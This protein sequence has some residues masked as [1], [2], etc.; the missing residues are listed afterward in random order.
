MSD[1]RV[2]QA[3]HSITRTLSST[4]DQ[5]EGLR[6]TLEIAAQ[7]VDATGGSIWQHNPD[8]RQLVCRHVVGEK[9]A[10]LVGFT[11]GDAEG[12]AGHVFQ[13]RTAQSDT[14]L[15]TNPRH[16]HRVDEILQH[17]TQSLVTVP[18]SY[19]GG[20]AVGVIQLVNKRGG[21]FT[22]EDLTV[23]DIVA[24]VCAMSLLNA[25]LAQQAV[26]TEALGYVAGFA[27]DIYNKMTSFVTGLPTLRMLLDDVFTAV[28][29]ATPEELAR[30]REDAFSFVDFME[31]DA[32][33]VYRYAR[34]IARL[35]KDKPLDTR[36]EQSDLVETARAQVDQLRRNAGDLDVTL[37]L[38]GD[39]PIPCLHDRLLVGSA[40]Y[41]LVNNALPETRGGAVSVAVREENGFA[42]LEVRDTGRGMPRDVLDS[43]LHGS[44]ISTKAGGSGIGTMIVKKVAE[45]HGGTLE[46]ESTE[47]VGTT[48]RIRLPLLVAG[49]AP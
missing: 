11:M 48:F 20:V 29:T 47:G 30:A 31:T 45:I 21:N 13:T 35:A 22:P 8:K 19:P 39:R 37:Q 7:F 34:F 17:Q 27:H 26:K 2:V 46:G 43:I 16:A 9:A 24:G 36:F 32:D 44:A 5:S 49:A 33:V 4:L 38:A 10:A 28:N 14:D 3:V 25:D 18:I 41:N 1:N 6:R 12:I 40:V 15:P 42:V 23:L